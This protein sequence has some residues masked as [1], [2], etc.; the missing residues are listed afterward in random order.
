MIQL[1]EMNLKFAYKF[2]SNYNKGETI[3]WKKYGAHKK[4]TKQKK[5]SLLF[6]FLRLKWPRTPKLP[7][8]QD[9]WENALI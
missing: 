1:W 7:T 6:L 9:F 4:K 3:C 2:T 8:S 5:E